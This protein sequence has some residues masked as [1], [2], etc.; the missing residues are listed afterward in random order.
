MTIAEGNLEPRRAPSR[1][2]DR[3]FP[4]S[5]R[6][7]DE[8]AVDTLHNRIPDGVRFDMRAAKSDCALMQQLAQEHANDMARRERMDHSGFHSRAA[9]GARAENVAM[10]SKTEAEAMA[11]WQNSPG[12]AANMRLAGCKAVAHTVSRSGRHYW[13]M[14][15][16]K[17]PAELASQSTRNGTTRSGKI[18]TWGSSFPLLRTP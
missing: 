3:L 15:I 16:G 14:E 9:R 1:S 13:V 11:Q 6:I 10:G 4:G 2:D 17:S 8:V 18:G 7:I 5:K 12:H